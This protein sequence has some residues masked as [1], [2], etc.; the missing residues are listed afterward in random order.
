VT[1]G[2]LTAL[3][4]K[5]LVLTRDHITE[6]GLDSCGSRLLPADSLLVTSRATIGSVALVRQPTATNQ[7]FKSIVFK[8]GCDPSFYFHLF[9]RLIPELERRASGTTFLEISGREFS[10][11]RLPVPS[12]GEQRDVARIL[13]TLDVAIRSTEH[14]VAKLK[15][16]KQGVLHDL[17]TRGVD[18]NGELRD[19][20][21]HPKELKESVLGRIP[22][23]WTA[24]LLRE[25]ADISKLAG[26]EY[27]S[28]VRY[29]DDGEIIA[30]RPMNIKNERIDLSEIQRIKRSVSDALPRSKVKAGDVVVTYIGAYIGETALIEEDDRFHLAPNIA[31]VRPLAVQPEFLLWSTRHEHVQ[32]QIRRFTSVTA[33]PSMTMASLRSVYV[34]VPPKGEQDELSQR[35]VAA[36]RRQLAEE[37]V[38]LA[39]KQLKLGLVD[40]LLTGRVRVTGLCNDVAA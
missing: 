13:D 22:R 1:P 32:S 37:K 15:Q 14:L 11:V 7:G 17:L 23:S 2:E 21:R 10:A 18:D 27:T 12:E 19:P 28:L 35:V 24:M 36:H 26:Y 33:T 31:R 8:R 30:I 4:T 34:P 20:E 9:R 16:V 29:R 40:D 39:L 38:V 25:A 5:Y 3:S 6:A